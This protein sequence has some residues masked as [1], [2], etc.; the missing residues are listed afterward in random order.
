MNPP[1][2]FYYYSA[3]CGRTRFYPN[4]CVLRCGNLEWSPEQKR[5]LCKIGMMRGLDALKP[6]NARKRE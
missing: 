4:Y 1:S 3:A 6:R 5:Y 2:N